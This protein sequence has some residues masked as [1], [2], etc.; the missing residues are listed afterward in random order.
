MSTH[1]FL[2]PWNTCFKAFLVLFCFGNFSF[3][4]A[5]NTIKKVI[6]AN[7]ITTVTVN[8]NQI[9]NILVTTTLTDK[10]SVTS[11]LDG[12]Y[13][14]N[15]QIHSKLNEEELVLNLEYISFEAIPDD[16][17]NAHK[18]IAATLK[19][20]IPNHI[21]LKIDSD[22]GSVDVIG[23]FNSLSVELLQGYCKVNATSKNT[24]I[25]T[26]D[27]NIE[28]I[29]K[30][31]I[32]KAISKNGE[33]ITENIEPSEYLWHLNSINGNITVFRKE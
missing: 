16:K 18:V 4:N 19:L 11:T 7:D 21:N 33:V 31:A 17:R 2:R 8:G 1:R 30:N 15:Y 29:T 6:D 25:N 14:N 10:I 27:G 22:V 3:I 24:I 23:S 9:F 32:V 26:I 20:E 5:Q 13:Q 28:V 12:E